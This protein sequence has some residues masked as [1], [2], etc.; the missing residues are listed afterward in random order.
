MKIDKFD[1]EY[2]FL[3]NFYACSVVYEG[4]VYPSSEHAYQAAKTLNQKAR[5]VFTFPFMTAGMS[6][7]LGQALELRPNWD[8]IKLAQ[9]ASILEAKFDNDDLRKALIA[10]GDAELIEGNAW[11]DTYWGVCN[12]KGNNFL[13]KLLMELRKKLTTP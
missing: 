12:G 11:G 9:M 6:K 10:T 7:H 4:H 5:Y 1:G 8:K 13:G 3:S 2:Q